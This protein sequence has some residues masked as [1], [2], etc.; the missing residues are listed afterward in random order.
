ML[1][2]WGWVKHVVQNKSGYLTGTWCVSLLALFFGA[3]PQATFHC[4]AGRIWPAGRY[5]R[6]PALNTRK[7]HFNSLNM[8]DHSGCYALSQK[9]YSCM[10]KAK[11]CGAFWP[12]LWTFVF[13]FCFAL[14]CLT[15][16]CFAFFPMSITFTNL[17]NFVWWATSDNVSIVSHP[18]CSP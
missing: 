12:N 7:I 15:L 16:T 14:F 1:L 6:R 4:T 18:M 8:T 10:S 3:R 17:M 11:L 13:S 9:V 2:K 5:L